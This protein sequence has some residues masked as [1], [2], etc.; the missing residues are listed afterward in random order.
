MKQNFAEIVVD[1]TGQVGNAAGAQLMAI[2]E[3]RESRHDR[4]KANFGA[5]TVGKLVLDTGAAHFLPL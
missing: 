3:C 2:P 5:T 1:G 4:Y